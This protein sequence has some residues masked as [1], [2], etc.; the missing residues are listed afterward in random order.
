MMNEGHPLIVD[1]GFLFVPNPFDQDD[2]KEKD[3][4]V[5]MISQ[6]YRKVQSE[7]VQDITQDDVADG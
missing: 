3:L 7:Y 6:Y 2:L 5:R 1:G 4:A